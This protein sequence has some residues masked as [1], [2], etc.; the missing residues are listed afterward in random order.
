VHRYLL[1]AI[2]SV[3]LALGI[4]ASTAHAEVSIPWATQSSASTGSTVAPASVSTLADGSTIVTGQ[5]SGT[6]DF[7]FF[8]LTSSGSADIYVAKVDA[9]GE[10]VWAVRAG[11]SNSS[12]WDTGRGVSVLA[13]GSAIVTGSFRGTA[14][15]GE[16]TLVGDSLERD[17][18]F[19]AKISASGAFVWAT[20]GGGDA[21]GYCRGRDVS[22]LPDGSAI[23]T[24]SFTG[25]ANFGSTTPIANSGSGGDIFVARIDANGTFVWATRAGGSGN[26]SSY[27]VSVLSNG[28]AILTGYITPTATFA[29][30]TGSISLSG[31]NAETVF[32]AKVDA[33]GSFVWAT[34]AALGS[35]GDDA[36]GTRVSALADG[37]AILTGY[38]NGAADFGTTAI[39][40]NASSNDIFVAKID[41]SGAWVWATSTGGTSSDVGNSVSAFSD[42]SAIV[43]GYFRGTVAF[44]TS[45]VT[46]NTSSDDTFVAK[47]GGSGAWVWATSAGGTT[48]TDKGTG[49]SAMP[50]GSAIVVG[51]FDGVAVFGSITLT[52]TG[53][54][55]A[56]DGF[57]AK[58]LDAA[59]APAAPHAVAGDGQATVTITPLAGGSVTT[60]TVLSGPGGKTCTITAPATSCIVTGLTNGT[61]YTFTVTAT[62]TTGTSPASAPSNAITP[63][64]TT[65]ATTTTSTSTT[66]T[67]TKIDVVVLPGRTRLRSGETMRIAIR[68]SNSSK[69]TVAS[70]TTCLTLPANL[71]VT[72]TGGAQRAGR[73]LCFS[74]GSLAAGATRTRAVHVRAV[75]QQTVTRRVIGTARSSASRATLTTASSTPIRITPLVTP[76]ETVT[77]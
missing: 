71:V 64:S 60:Y 77:G 31:V 30:A 20:K 43:T 58:F 63:T 74:L 5:F 22:T 69:A 4:G 25:T 41:A 37:S 28:S 66:A 67:S 16:F 44:G 19:V 68:A 1:L 23:V 24:G 57:V 53:T 52:S 75:T 15:F 76:A 56:F 40:S 2:V 47:I 29:T 70:V 26:D 42:G 33:T 13:D 38:V 62:N 12:S 36:Q 45:S 61:S 14:D 18:M 9:S 3:S 21:S 72:H 50:D 59:Q 11:G 54:S 39:T 46:S 55:S 49:V 27:G 34:Q 48:S 10:Y 7:G 65:S 35:S 8:R 73:S 6:V 51:S 17:D 32:I